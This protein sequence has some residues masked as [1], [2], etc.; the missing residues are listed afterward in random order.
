MEYNKRKSFVYS[1]PLVLPTVLGH[2]QTSLRD[3]VFWMIWKRVL[4]LFTLWQEQLPLYKPEELALPSV[5]IKKVE[6]DKLTTYFELKLVNVT[7]HLHLDEQERKI[8]ESMIKNLH[9][10]LSLL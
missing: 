4:R 9:I 6:V 7:N 10:G 2:F 8:V 3:P 5:Q 1:V